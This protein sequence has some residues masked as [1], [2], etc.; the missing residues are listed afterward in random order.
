MALGIPVDAAP[1]DH[2]SCQCGTQKQ[3]ATKAG[4]KCREFKHLNNPRTYYSTLSLMTGT[5]G[6]E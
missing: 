1:T 2:G 5:A 6:I 4:G 3:I